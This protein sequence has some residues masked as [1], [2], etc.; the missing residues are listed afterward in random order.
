MLGSHSPPGIP[1]PLNTVSF[2]GFPQKRGGSTHSQAIVASG[3]HRNLHHM[4][5]PFVVGTVVSGHQ[6][7]EVGQ[8]VVEVSRVVHMWEDFLRGRLPWADTQVSVLPK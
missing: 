4:V 8:P 5:C 2:C 7:S 1:Q 3:G 6:F